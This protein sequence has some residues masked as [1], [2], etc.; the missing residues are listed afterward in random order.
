MGGNSE[1]DGKSETSRVDKFNDW[2]RKAKG[3][4]ADAQFDLGKSYREGYGVTQDLS[5]AV[6]WYQKSAEQG[7]AWAKISLGRCYREG[8]GVTQ[9]LS[10]AVR[11]YQK[12][13]EQG[14]ALGQSQ[15]GFCYQ[16]GVGVTKDLSEAFR[17]YQQS[18][19]Q[20]GARA[21][22]QLGI[23]YQFGV[24][25]TKDLSEAFRWFQKAAEQGYAYAQ[26]SLGSC[27]AAGDGV[28]QDLSEA[29]R[30]YQKAAEQGYASSQHSLANA[31]Y[32]GEGVPQDYLRAHMW[33][34]LATASVTFKGGMQGHFEEFRSK[35]SRHLSPSQVVDAQ[36]L[37]RDWTETASTVN[38]P[39]RQWRQVG[40]ETQSKPET[41]SIAGELRDGLRE[42]QRTLEITR[43][44]TVLD[45][46]TTGK[47]TRGKN[48]ARVVQFS[49]WSVTPDGNVTDSKT[50]LDVDVINPG[51]PIPPG[52]TEKHGIED[53][54]VK[55]KPTFRQVAPRL[56]E[57]L[58]DRDYVAY[59]YTYDRAVLEN[60]FKR[61]DVPS[62]FQDGVWVCPFRIWR[63]VWENEPG[64]RKLGNALKR[65]TGS[66]PD[67]RRAHQAG[68]DVYM[69]TRVLVGQL[70]ELTGTDRF[71][72]SVEELGGLTSRRKQNWLDSNGKIAW[73]DGSAILNFGKKHQGRT[74][75][76]IAKT[77]DGYLKWM[78]ED[79]FEEDVKMIIRDALK[80]EFPTKAP[81]K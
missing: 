70:R 35:V 27:Y 49:A 23:C 19:D 65:F 68:Y 44:L 53:K 45:V 80:G 37:A 28:T 29:V 31:F 9:D 4:D 66:L 48:C 52:S 20:G 60:E 62:P 36:K 56:A 24:G 34:N 64:A 55:D 12:A 33:A 18:A 11:W 38:A 81:T 15:L 42:I 5:E 7:N 22:L 71:P 40:V 25:V 50:Q 1:K 78:L 13:A 26:D 46:E 17:W 61:A 32:K 63:R 54:D 14:N 59:N 79:D 75:Q 74:L 57:W 77:D 69:A 58:K 2:L 72:S 16:Y 43:P 39:L 51:I 10:E 3:G 76:E 21:Q 47:E 30:W 41:P 73:R 6:R 67:E 8:D